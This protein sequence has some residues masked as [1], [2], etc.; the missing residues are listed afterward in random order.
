M[1]KKIPNRTKAN[2]FKINLKYTTSKKREENNKKKEKMNNDKN[3][4]NIFNNI[5]T[6]FNSPLNKN[7]KRNNS[8]NG[9]KK[10]NLFSNQ[11][12]DLSNK[13][14]NNSN[15]KN[16]KYTL[17]TIIDIKD[18]QQMLKLKNN[19]LL[20]YAAFENKIYIYDLNNFKLLQNFKSEFQYNNF[21]ELTDGTIGLYYFINDSNSGVIQGIELL[22][23]KNEGKE[24]EIISKIEN[25]NFT[26]T[27]CSLS[28]GHFAIYCNNKILEIYDKEGKLKRSINI[29][30]NEESQNENIEILLMKEIS[31][32]NLILAT[33]SQL[34]ILNLN[35]KEI[36]KINVDKVCDENDNNELSIHIETPFIIKINNKL[37]AIKGYNGVY[38][39]NIDLKEVIYNIENL[40]ED[41][42]PINVLVVDNDENFFV[43]DETSNISLMRLEDNKFKELLRIRKD[44]E[45][46]SACHS[47]ILSEEGNLI[48]SMNSRIEIFKKEKK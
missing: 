12:F 8:F 45:G 40:I 38:I 24:Y 5:N 11:L 42:I 14:D 18:V 35:E 30:I 2:V 4:K 47:L 27:I 6:Y 44:D 41:D 7:I 9:S 19:R 32:N 33:P 29:E 15:N 31:N 43:G 13:M 37:F 21:I 23:L 34:Y 36:E 48:A 46:N 17:M 28:D 22:K 26:S 1:P 16:I 10:Y 20:M 3:L 39:C 25:K